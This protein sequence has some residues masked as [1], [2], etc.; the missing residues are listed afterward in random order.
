MRKALTV[1]VLILILV[2]AGGTGVSAS[3]VPY[4]VGFGGQESGSSQDGD[5]HPWGGTRTEEQDDE[6]LESKY[7]RH[8]A[9]TGS[10]TFE[11]IITG[12]ARGF[13]LNSWMPIIENRR[14]HSAIR[15]QHGR[16]DD[17]YVGVKSRPTTRRQRT[18]K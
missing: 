15:H 4:P 7:T 8:T 2:V 18:R 14:L 5:D 12:F 6:A 13:L 10:C 16:I 1:S 3:E 11:F 17:D 9:A